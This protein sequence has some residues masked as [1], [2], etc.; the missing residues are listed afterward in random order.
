MAALKLAEQKKAIE[1]LAKTFAKDL[2]RE[3]F[4]EHA[5]V[6]AA[7]TILDEAIHVGDQQK[8]GPR[9]THLKVISSSS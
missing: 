9:K 5:L 2:L 3:G 8:V 1:I 7:T 4:D 6:Q